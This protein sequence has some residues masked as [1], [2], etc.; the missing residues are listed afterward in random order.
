[1]A[2]L[3]S[4]QQIENI[5][6]NMLQLLCLLKEKRIALRDLKPD[7]LFMDAD[8]DNYPV[9]LK[10][11]SAFSIGVIDVETAVS[12]IPLPDGTIAQ[13]LIG[14]TP[15]Y[16]TPLHLLRNKT[17]QTNFGDL[18]EALHLQDWYSTI[19]IIFKSV[20]GNNLFPRAARSFP[21][22]LKILKS[23]RSKAAPDES[24]VKAMCQ[25]FWAA[26]A[27]DIR[28]QLTTFADVLNQLNLSV[29]EAMAPAIESE[30]KREE[31]CLVKAIHKHI[32]FSPLLRSEK[33]R[34]FLRPLS[35]K[36]YE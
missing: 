16:A 4:R 6:S 20:T 35:V 2:F 3:K 19:A 10:D 31:A 29:P 9:F 22:L 17:I 33:N 21:A 18:A 25:R 5:A 14:G 24:T 1:M 11:S 12:L 15:L 36:A 13:P 34:N 8:P 30:L 27:A 26:A 23:S 7:N 32:S 28:S